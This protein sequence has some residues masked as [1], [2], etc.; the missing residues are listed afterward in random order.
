MPGLKDKYLNEVAPALKSKFNY[1]S[2]MEVPKLEKVVLNM[3]IGDAKDDPKAL[4]AA[5]ND[6]TLISGQ[7]PI[8]TKAKKSVAA[9]KLRTGMNVGCKVTLRGDRMYDFVHKLF[10]VALPR[11]RDFRGVPVNSF[12]GRGNY[13]LGVKEQLIFPEIDYDKVEKIRGMDITFV[14]T[15][16]TDEEAR[17]LLKLM[18]MPFTQS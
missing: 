4:D 10:N 17:E 14:T 9:F 11:V 18:G 1:K 7:K 12:D 6:L 3:G 2:V 8:V 5:V 13:S 16:K 15:A